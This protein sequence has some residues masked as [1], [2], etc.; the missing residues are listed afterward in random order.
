ML[1]PGTNIIFAPSGIT[2]EV[3]S[4]EMHHQ[5]LAEALPGDNIGFYIKDVSVDQLRRGFVVGQA[6]SDPPKVASSFNAQVSLTSENTSYRCCL[7]FSH[8]AVLPFPVFL[9]LVDIF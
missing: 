2:A 5:S 1:K 6:N 7:C 3:K 9:L 4:V 8:K